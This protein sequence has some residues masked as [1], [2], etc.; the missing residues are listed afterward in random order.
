MSTCQYQHL[1]GD[2]WALFFETGRRFCL[3]EFP[4]PED[5]A[6]YASTRTYADGE[7]ECLECGHTWR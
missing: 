7:T 2:E 6:H 5:C 3:C 4:Q 1:H